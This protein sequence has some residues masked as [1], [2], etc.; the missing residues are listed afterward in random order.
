M[1][2]NFLDIAIANPFSSSLL[3]SLSNFTI[4]LVWS[5][6]NTIV[7]LGLNITS[8]SDSLKTESFKY[9]L[10]QDTTGSNQFDYT[11]TPLL[12]IQK[13][14]LQFFQLLLYYY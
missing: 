7:A 10:Y 12:K 1:P 11:A 4:V 3:S 8:I 13:F 9:A 14:Y 5:L 6:Q 2:K